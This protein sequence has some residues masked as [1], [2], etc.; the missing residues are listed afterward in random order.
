MSRADAAGGRAATA[1]AAAPPA[2][3]PA[4]TPTGAAVSSTP[5]PRQPARQSRLSTPERLRLLSA[6]TVAIGVAVGVIAALVL[7]SVGYALSRAQDDVAQLIRV[8]QIQNYL[9]SADATATNAFL[10]GGLE[11]PEQRARYDEAITETA[12]LIAAAADA[13][14]ADAE[15]LAALNKQVVEYAATIEQARANNRQGLPVGAQYLRIA[16]SQLRNQ[17]LPLLHN[18]VDANAARADSEMARVNLGYLFPAAALLGLGGLVLIQVTVARQFH[19]RIN[20]GLLAAS[21]VLLVALVAGLVAAIQLDSRVTAARE[22]SFARVNT[23][24]AARIAANDAKSN[25]S[26][27]LIARGSGQAFDKAWGASAATVDAGLTTLGDG[28][29]RADWDGYQSTHRRI[30]ELDDGGRWEDAVTLATGTGASSANATF[31]AFDER[32]ATVLQTATEE[33]TTA[34]S[35]RLAGLIVGLF[36]LVGAGIGTAVLGRSG[37]AQRREEYR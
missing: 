17:A 13:Q 8:Q 30:R 27:T 26:L 6:T 35:G 31:G 9:L 2:T 29:L 14:P 25:E 18:L 33:T 28:A 34:L 21:A 32:I 4:P 12:T 24:A 16:S 19:R 3:P 36:L 10:V 37:L 11:P 1:A 23:A 22:D 20:V 5:A 7:G 15:A